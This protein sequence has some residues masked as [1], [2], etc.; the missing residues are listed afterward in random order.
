[1]I[2]KSLRDYISQCPYLYEF[3][4]GI[5]IDYL[6]NNSTTYSIEEVPCEPIIKRYING[7]TKRQYDFIFASRESYGADV[8]QNIENSG[9]YEDFSNW[10]E[11]QSVKGNLP[12]L[13]GNRESLEIKVST[14]GYAFQTDDNSARY[15]I[16]LKLIYFQKGGF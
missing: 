6:D 4:K 13:E 12:S 11:E 3:N 5:N 16:Q 7:D 2:I 8:F 1:M 9:F 10:I 15:Q 14:T